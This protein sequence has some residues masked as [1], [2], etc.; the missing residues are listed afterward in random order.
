MIGYLY[1]G[2]LANNPGSVA[3]FWKGLA[4][5]GYIQGR[6]VRAEYREAKNDLS[7]VPD[8]VRDL[9]RREVSLIAVPGSG[10]TARVA[11]A[12][13]ATNPIV[14]SNAGNPL[15]S[16]LVTSL[17]RPGGNVTGITDFGNDLSAKRLELIKLCGAR[18]SRIGIL[19]HAQLHVDRPRDR[20]RPPNAP[21]L[22]LETTEA[23]VGEPQEIDAAFAEF[24]Q[25][26]VDASTSRRARC[27]SL[28]VR[29]SWRWRRGIAC[30]RSTRSSCIRRPAVS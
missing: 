30:R 22:S 27:S 8:L 11:M 9:V 19:H 1:A 5:L 3:A 13:T 28:S 17:S 10:P 25:A 29:K 15:Q 6:N 16:G 2:S 4:E 7:R 26:G 21:A 14:F 24:V 23:V 18:L 12:A 20:D